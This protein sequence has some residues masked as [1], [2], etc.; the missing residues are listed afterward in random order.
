VLLSSLLVKR[1]RRVYDDDD[2]DDDGENDGVFVCVFTKG[3]LDLLNKRE[4]SG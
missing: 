3:T 1:R 4:R 2:D